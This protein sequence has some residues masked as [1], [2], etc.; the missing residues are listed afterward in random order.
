MMGKHRH[1]ILSCQLCARVLAQCRCPDATNKKK[2]YGVC[3]SCKLIEDGREAPL[4]HEQEPSQT[5]PNEFD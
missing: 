2:E 4:D 1:Y 3:G 5:V